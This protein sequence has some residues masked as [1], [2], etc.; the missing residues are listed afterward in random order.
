MTS[1]QSTSST[2]QTQVNTLNQFSIWQVVKRHI[3]R[4]LATA[5]VDIILPLII[6][7]ILPITYEDN[8]NI[9][10]AIYSTKIALL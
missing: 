3:P 2:V 4:V 1:S 5:L 8:F 6:Y 7:F 9:T 10:R